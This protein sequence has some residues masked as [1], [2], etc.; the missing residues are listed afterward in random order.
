MFGNLEEQIEQAHGH[1]VNPTMRVLRR[2]GVL[3]LTAVLF[4]SLY[5]GILLL[6]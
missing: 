4:G 2:L 3:G 6:G 5:L 1:A